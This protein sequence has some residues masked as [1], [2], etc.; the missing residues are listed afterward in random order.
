MRY[1]LYRALPKKTPLFDWTVLENQKELEAVL[2][3]AVGALP[4]G[5]GN[6]RNPSESVSCSRTTTSGE[7]SWV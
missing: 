6:G 2:R 1:D 7:L 4:L 5:S 3:R